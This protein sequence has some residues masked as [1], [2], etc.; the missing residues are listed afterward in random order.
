MPSLN[1]KNG[2]ILTRHRKLNWSHFTY[3][4]ELL[5]FF[6]STGYLYALKSP[7]LPGAFKIGITAKTPEIRAAEVSKE[8]NIAE[9]FCVSFKLRL[10]NY[11][12]AEKFVHSALKLNNVEFVKSVD[13]WVCAETGTTPTRTHRSSEVFNCSVGQL[14]DRFRSVESGDERLKM[15]ERDYLVDSE[16]CLIQA[17]SLYPNSTAIL[18]PWKAINRTFRTRLNS[19]QLCIQPAY[20]QR[21]CGQDS[22]F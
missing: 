8:L 1:G 9:P 16:K 11:V 12:M 21:E 10:K 4:L 17:E 19:G 15:F 2:E 22:L 20:Q 13:R 18:F 5:P 3:I 14:E 7:C 6:D